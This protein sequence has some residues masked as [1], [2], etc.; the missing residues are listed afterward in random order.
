M[1]QLELLVYGG[2]VATLVIGFLGEIKARI[3]R[4]DAKK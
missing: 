2:L 1:S 3:N 4:R